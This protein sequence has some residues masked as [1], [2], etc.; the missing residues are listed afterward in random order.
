MGL[1]K[2]GTSGAVGVHRQ[3]VAYGCRWSATGRKLGS[4]ESHERPMGLLTFYWH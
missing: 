1:H 3:R 4:P 2:V